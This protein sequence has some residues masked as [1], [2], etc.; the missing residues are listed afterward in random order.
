MPAVGA[1]QTARPVH[2]RR[3]RR[4]VSRISLRK[5]LVHRQ[6]VCRT[7]YNNNGRSIRNAG[8]KDCTWGNE[9][10]DVKYDR[11]YDHFEPPNTIFSAISNHHLVYYITPE[12]G[13][14]TILA[15]RYSLFCHYS[16]LFFL[17]SLSRHLSMIYWI[18]P[19]LRATASTK[20][21]TCS[22]I[23]SMY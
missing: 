20:V 19:L 10:S 12:A 21:C 15:M 14:P 8:S 17:S 6:E 9:I 22:C 4:V 1:V 18:A 2:I 16:S 11:Q 5:P 23:L 13:A 3:L 7:A